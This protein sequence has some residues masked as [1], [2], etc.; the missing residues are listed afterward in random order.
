MCFRAE[1]HKGDPYI[2]D[3]KKT[4]GHI[5][6]LT[7]CQW[8]PNDKQLFMTAALDSTVRIWDSESFRSQKYC[9][10]ARNTAS[11][12]RLSSGV[13]AAA[14]SAD[15]S[16]VFGARLDGCLSAWDWKNSYLKP[17]LHVGDAH[18]PNTETSRLAISQDGFTVVSR[19]GDGTMKG[20]LILTVNYQFLM[21]NSLGCSSF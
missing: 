12:N 13:T 2:R 3:M 6:G 16:L 4:T 19:G 9:L 14:F 5:A 17:K 1:Y 21:V 8:H 18:E 15:G 20:T 10:V 7:C 11:G